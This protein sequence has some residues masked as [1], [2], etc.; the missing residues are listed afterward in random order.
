MTN[1]RL[2]VEDGALMAGEHI[3][4]VR[5]AAGDCDSFDWP[6]A[7]DSKPYLAAALFDMREMGQVE[8]GHTV[9]LPDGTEFDIDS[10]LRDLPALD[11]FQER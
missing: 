5:Y 6:L 7:D 8:G 1:T 9:T 4:L 3:V 10:E 2:T 11:C